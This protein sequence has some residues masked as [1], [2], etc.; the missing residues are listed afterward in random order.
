MS[1]DLYTVADAAI[2]CVFQDDH[3]GYAL[4]VRDL[5]A[6]ELRRLGA[7]LAARAMDAMIGRAEDHG[8]GPE[9]AGAIWQRWILHREQQASED[10]TRGG[11]LAGRACG[12]GGTGASG[13]AGNGTGAS[14]GSGGTDASGE[15][16]GSPGADG[17]GD[18]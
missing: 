2:G 7:R 16:G 18:E 10:A 15:A 9:E 8:V 4:L 3:E 13:D 14:E 17:S 1:H 11:R 5:D 12:A 6:V